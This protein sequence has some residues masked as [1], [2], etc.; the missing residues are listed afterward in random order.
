[1]VRVCEIKL[2]HMGKTMEIPIWCARKCEDFKPDR[3]VYKYSLKVL[4]IYV[5][6]HC[7]KYLKEHC[8]FC[9]HSLTHRES[10]INK[11]KTCLSCDKFGYLSR[12][13]LVDKNEVVPFQISPWNALCKKGILFKI[14]LFSKPNFKTNFSIKHHNSIISVQSIAF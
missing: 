7:S 2:S 1:M 14:P 11:A 3:S 5:Y 4:Y 12:M 13:M 10:W 9:T 6:I 8:I